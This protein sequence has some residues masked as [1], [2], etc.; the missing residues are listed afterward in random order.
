MPSLVMGRMLIFVSGKMFSKNSGLDSVHSN[1]EVP[2]EYSPAAS[3][4][5]HYFTLRIFDIK[6]VI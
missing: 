6:F 4:L 3:F 1:A 2:P 5:L